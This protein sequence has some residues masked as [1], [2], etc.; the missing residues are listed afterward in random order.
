MWENDDPD[1]DLEDLI[2]EE[3]GGRPSER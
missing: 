1:A 3:D 2:F